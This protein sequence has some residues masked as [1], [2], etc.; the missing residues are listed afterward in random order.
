MDTAGLSP[1][2]GHKG[3]WKDEKDLASGPSS[4]AEWDCSREEEPCLQCH[5]LPPEVSKLGKVAP[6]TGVNIEA[7]GGEEEGGD[8]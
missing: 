8:V 5:P 2:R 1:G 3:R 6:M 4:G 7:G